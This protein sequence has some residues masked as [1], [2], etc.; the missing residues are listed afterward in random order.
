MVFEEL[1]KMCYDV[2]GMVRVK[3]P[4]VDKANLIKGYK[5]WN[6]R[7]VE[8][9]PKSR[10]LVHE[11]SEGWEPLCKFLEVK[12]CPTTP[13]PR[14]NDGASM[15]AFMDTLDL[16]ARFWV[17]VV[18]GVPVGFVLSVRTCWRAVTRKSKTA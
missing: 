18:V 8:S 9:L 7:V 12:N 14:V 10:L 16:F 2:T 5:E 6:K 17:V 13:Y 11:S 15:K 3:D 4:I 1:I